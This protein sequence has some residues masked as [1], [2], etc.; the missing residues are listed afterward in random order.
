MRISADADGAY[1]QPGE[2]T[3]GDKGSPKHSISE[4]TDLSFLRPFGRI[5]IQRMQVG[6]RFK[7]EASLHDS[8]DLSQDIPVA[9][10]FTNC[11][12]TLALHKMWLA[13]WVATSTR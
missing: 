12:S 3:M 11:A 6:H 5:T 9:S 2:G 4:A 1:M 13:M 7:K 10:A 8:M